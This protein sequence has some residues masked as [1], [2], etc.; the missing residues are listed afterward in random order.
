M[1]ILKPKI[2]VNMPAVTHNMPCPILGNNYSAVYHCNKG[3]FE[4]SWEA[5]GM[6]WT[7]IRLPKYIK[8]L[9]KYYYA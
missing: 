9:L 2:N 7:T 4:P 6:G 8:K 1:R 5:Q 3:V